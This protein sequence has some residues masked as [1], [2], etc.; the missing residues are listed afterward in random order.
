MHGAVPQL[1]NI[2]ELIYYSG[3]DMRQEW[4]TN[5]L[6]KEYA[7]AGPEGN[8][9]IGRPKMRLLGSV[10][11]RSEIIGERNWN[12]RAGWMEEASEEG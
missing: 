4:A 7:L 12:R 8:R 2:L 9:G 10:D 1:Q 6:R 5:E 11:Q 3:Q